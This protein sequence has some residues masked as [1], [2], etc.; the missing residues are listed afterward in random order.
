MTA[1]SLRMMKLT[2]EQEK[3]LKLRKDWQE[4]LPE[5]FLKRVASLVEENKEALRI[6][7]KR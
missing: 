6:L 5:E 7:S 2:P 1:E 3:A 4:K